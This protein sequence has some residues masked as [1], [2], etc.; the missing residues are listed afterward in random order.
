MAAELFDEFVDLEALA[1]DLADPDP[2]VRRVAVLRLAETADPG[3]VPLLARALADP[4]GQVRLQAAGALGGFD[5]PE[6]A[7][8]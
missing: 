6:V 2:G 5:G 7:A 3:T 1:D 4:D 8:P